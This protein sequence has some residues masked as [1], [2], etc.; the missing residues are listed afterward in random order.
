MSLY[1]DP[2]SLIENK[3]REVLL[4]SDLD[5]TSDGPAS[6]A[7]V[8]ANSGG[9]GGVSDGN[10]GDI[11]VSGSGSVWKLNKNAMRIIMAINAS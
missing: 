2:N 5:Q 4:Y 7:Y 10:K 11:T 9:G 8:D 6:K 1:T 3:R